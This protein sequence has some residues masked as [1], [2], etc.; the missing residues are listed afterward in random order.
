MNRTDRIAASVGRRAITTVC[1]RA[2]RREAE[3]VFEGREHVPASGPTLLVAR[4]VHHLFDGCII[5][6]L[7]PR[8]FRILVAID[9]VASGPPRGL[10]EWAC[11][12][13]GWPTVIR[14][15][16]PRTQSASATPLLRQAMRQSV[17]LLRNGEMLLVFPE[18]YPTIDPH[19]TPQRGLEAMLP[20][21]PGFARL[22]A[23][24]EVDGRTRVAVVP[25]GFTYRGGPP[26][27]ITGTCGSPLFL[28]PGER[29]EA[30]ARRVEREVSTLSGLSN[31][32]HDG[33]F[34]RA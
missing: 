4:H 17:A 9:W 23:L 28:E 26:W 6:T 1:R 7:M 32:G 10:V 15:D 30:F 19:P 8:P 12:T 5:W 34:D 33:R 21:R 3:L 22:A 11:R 16:A 31:A 24:A 29:P 27:A 20:F 13:M 14:E 25:V 2:L 18:A